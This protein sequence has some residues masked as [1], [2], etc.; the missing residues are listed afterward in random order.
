MQAADR[1]DAVT[2]GVA[3][4]T[5]LGL[6]VDETTVLQDSNRVT[7]RLLPC[8]VLVQVAREAHGAAP[9]EI[10]LAQRLAATGSPVAVPDP[11][12]PPRVYPQQGFQVSLWTYYPSVRRPEDA[13]AEYA[14]ALRRLHAGLR[15]LDVA[16]PHFTERV[17]QAQRLVA[18][19]DR[20]PALADADRAFLGDTL[21]EL[22][23]SVTA[24]TT[25]DQLLHGEP[26]PG[27]VLAT[28]DGMRFIDLETCCRGPV[29][30]DLAHAPE[31]VA[32]HYPDVDRDL[33]RD[34]RI[35]TSA[36]ATTWRWD[37]DDH[38]PDGARLGI[39]WLEELRSALERHRPDRR[40]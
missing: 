39:E 35:L 11:R 34:C 23:R 26:H 20:T 7:L 40:R 29:E 15:G 32:E 24:R 19:H 13:P 2:A 21:R 36:I 5:A 8:D 25:T 28:P 10:D 18:D 33:L 6:R 16:A 12:V 37:R 31:P 38:F 4:A 3:T 9:F 30:F 17:E 14:G 22:H 27:N 1:R